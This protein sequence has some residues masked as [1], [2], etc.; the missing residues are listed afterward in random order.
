MANEKTT[1]D[2]QQPGQNPVKDPKE[3]KTGDEPMTG[4]QNSYLHTLARE[5][6]DE[7]DD[8]MTKSEASEKIDE[9]QHKTGRGL[10]ASQEKNK[11]A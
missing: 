7:V 1:Q 8:S 5:A 9:L 6:G 11:P 4:P 2:Q 3:W 10:P